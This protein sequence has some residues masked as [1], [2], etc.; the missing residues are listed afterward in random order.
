MIIKDQIKIILATLIL[1]PIYLIS[2]GLAGFFTLVATVASI[3][4][5]N[6]L[7]NTKD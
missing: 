2:A 3:I 4:G 6:L 1:F 5:L 7:K